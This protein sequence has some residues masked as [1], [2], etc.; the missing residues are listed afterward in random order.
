MPFAISVPRHLFQMHLFSGLRCLQ[1]CK[2]LLG[3]TTELCLGTQ[4]LYKHRRRRKRPETEVLQKCASKP[5]ARI[6]APQA[7]SQKT[8]TLKLTYSK[9]CKNNEHLRQHVLTCHTTR[10]KTSF[11]KSNRVDGSLWDH[12]PGLGLSAQILP[13]AMPHDGLIALCD[14]GWHRRNESFR[15]LSLTLWLNSRSDVWPFVDTS[16]FCA[17]AHLHLQCCLEIDQIGILPGLKQGKTL[18]KLLLWAGN[19]WEIQCL[20]SNLNISGYQVLFPKLH[21][22]HL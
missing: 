1:R 5:S 22:C 7:L 4:R 6:S 8:V 3:G 10:W 18:P 11:Q 20:E 14:S 16:F 12:L 19:T 15:N 13:L 21:V 17:F 9:R 2:L